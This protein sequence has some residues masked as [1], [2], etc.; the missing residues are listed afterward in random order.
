MATC[1]RYTV[2]AGQNIRIPVRTVP[3]GITAIPGAGGTANVR[4]TRSPDD[5]GTVNWITWPQ[6]AVSSINEGGIVWPVS[7]VELSATTQPAVF[8]VCE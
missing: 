8:E 5:G 1:T 2:P 7:M 4:Y 6:G 3:L